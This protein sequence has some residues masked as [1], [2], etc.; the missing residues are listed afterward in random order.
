MDDLDNEIQTTDPSEIGD[1]EGSEWDG[2]ADEAPLEEQEQ[3]SEVAVAATNKQSRNGTDSKPKSIKAQDARSKPSVSE[4]SG[5]D[6]LEESE[7]EGSD[8]M[9]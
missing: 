5:F 6:I 2:F 4:P 9:S 1:G 3:P 7:D 8:S